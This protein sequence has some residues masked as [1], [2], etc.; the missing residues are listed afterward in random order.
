MAPMLRGWVSTWHS[1]FD[2]AVDR[3]RCCFDKPVL[4]H[5]FPRPRQRRRRRLRHVP[6]RPVG[7]LARRV[8]AEL[9]D[10]AV[11]SSGSERSARTPGTTTKSRSGFTRVAIAHSTCSASQGSMSSSTTITCLIRLTAAHTANIALRASPGRGARSATTA[12]R[13]PAPP[14]PTATS[15]T[16]AHG[17]ADD[18]KQPGRDGDA[19]EQAMLGMVARQHRPGTWRRCGGVRREKVATMPAP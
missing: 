18:A 1:P 11:R 14:S 7:R 17:V 19:A 9:D 4:A 3:F 15:P 8:D 12:C 16:D 10:G 13:R 5:D 6:V 2:E